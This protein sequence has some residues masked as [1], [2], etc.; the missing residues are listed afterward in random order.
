MCEALGGRQAA[1][2][3]EALIVNQNALF[4]TIASQMA[5]GHGVGVVP[6]HNL[7]AARHAVHPARTL[8]PTLTLPLPLPVTLTRHAMHRRH[9][10]SFHNQKKAGNPKPKPKP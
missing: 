10:C 1:D 8:T 3:G 9:F 5:R 7:T 6:F 4:N 2:D